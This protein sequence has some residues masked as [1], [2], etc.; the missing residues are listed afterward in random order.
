MSAPHGEENL[1]QNPSAPRELLI[2]YATETGTARETADR[3]A[4]E[5]RRARFQSHVQ[6][7]D[8][9][10]QEALISEHLVIFVVSTTGWGAEPR[11]MTSLW[12]MLLRSDLPDDLFEDMFFCVFGLGDTAYEKFC[13]PAKK[14]SRRMQSLG[15]YEICPRGEGDEQHRLEIDGAL[16]PWVEHLLEVLLHL[17]PLPSP[18]GQD[19]IPVG[20]PPPRVSV[21]DVA[22]DSSPVPLDEDEKY[23]TALV[24]CNT[25]ITAE[26]W[27]QDVRHFEFS[28][29][30]DVKYNPGDVAVIHPFAAASE[31]DS[32]LVT[33]G[34]ASVADDLFTVEHTMR[35][36]TLP[37]H[38]PNIIS[39][40]ILF[41]RYLDFN[42]VPRRSFFQLLRYFATD[43]LEREKL[44]EFVSIEGADEMYDYC[45]HVKRTIWEVLSEFRSARIPREY[46]FDLFPPLRPREF[47]IASSIEFHPREI[48]LCVAIVRYRT[49]LKIPR[50][51]VCTSYLTGLQSGDTLRIGIRK[52][53]ISLPTDANTPVVCVGPGTGI[54][55]MRAVIEQRVFAGYSNTTLYFGCRSAHKDQHYRSEWEVYGEEQKL[56]YR[57]ACSRDGPEGSKRTYVQDL[58]RNDARDIWEILGPQQGILIISG[59]SNKMPAAVREA[60]QGAAETM[61][62]MSKSEAAE[63][64]AAMERDGRLIEECWS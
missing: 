64:V 3:I 1:I 6:S 21:R 15:G 46:V 39:L 17:Y 35:D 58:I 7:M 13:W 53:F 40:R 8:A 12:N 43:E 30:E 52:G 37:D 36:Q 48:H 32:F 22:S 2:L 42:A 54:A 25:R 29:K 20:R 14:L 60:V 23:H 38:L 16:D 26:D 57:V 45:Q 62:G 31:V 63:Y 18:H 50:K 47:S 24:K 11:A 56:R 10:P 51:G 33:M 9:Y 59:S 5:C 27:F 61:G 41:T 49:K 19:T 28:F 34:W 55:P 44:D 4:R